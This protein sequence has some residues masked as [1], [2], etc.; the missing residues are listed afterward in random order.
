MRIRKINYEYWISTND[1]LASIKYLREAKD[2]KELPVDE[3]FTMLEE[4]IK[5]PIKKKR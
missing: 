5:L 1:V 3:L 2:L 4:E